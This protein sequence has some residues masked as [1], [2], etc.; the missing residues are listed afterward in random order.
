[1][2]GIVPLGLR[3]LDDGANPTAL[4]WARVW[5]V[6]GTVGAISLL[7]PAGALAGGMAA[8]YA[9]ATLALAA[10][11]VL[12]LMHLM[13]LRPAELAVAA[14]LVSPA[15]GGVGLVAQRLDGDAALALLVGQAHIVGFA[16][17]LVA[18]LVCHAVG[19][20]PATVTAVAVPAGYLLTV[21]GYLTLDG[22]ELVGGIVLVVG[23]SMLAWALWAAVRPAAATATT[24]R[25]VATSAVALAL[26]TPIALLW[27]PGVVGTVAFAVCGLLGWQ[28]LA[29]EGLRS[30][31]PCSAQEPSDGLPQ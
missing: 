25:L 3:L 27:A 22:V 16:A 11:G 5:P 21:L 6:A 10:S 13:S 28:R 19:G 2:V 24:R 23:T 15:V 26:T 18:G 12:R 20:R 9:G 29:H 8:V 1:M 4:A 31:E 7:L 30:D 14:A 17:C